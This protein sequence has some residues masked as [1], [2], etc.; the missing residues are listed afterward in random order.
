[1]KVMRGR[2]RQL[3]GRLLDPLNQHERSPQ[4]GPRLPAFF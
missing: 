1:M 3:W 4:Q 2:F